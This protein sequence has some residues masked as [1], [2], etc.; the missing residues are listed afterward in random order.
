MKNFLLS[1]CL[2]LMSASALAQENV[3]SETWGQKLDLTIQSSETPSTW[4]L[5]SKVKQE[6]MMGLTCCYRKELVSYVQ[7]ENS[8]KLIESRLRE[9]QKR[10]RYTQFNEYTQP[11]L[12]VFATLQ[13]LDIYTTYRGL[14]YNCV[15]EMNPILGESPSII[16]MSAVKTLVLIPTI[17]SDINREVLTQKTMRQVNSMMFMVIVN[18]NAVRNRAKRDCIRK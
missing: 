10:L 16:K 15:R 4:V 8:R 13:L 11:Q 1:T 14:K 2:L 6:I 12:Y 17:E 9:N 7:Q 3:L 5:D 18:N